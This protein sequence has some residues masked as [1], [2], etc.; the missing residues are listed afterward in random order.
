MKTYKKKI[1][2]NYTL[3][4]LIKPKLTFEKIN[5]YNILFI[6]NKSKIISVQSLI[7]NGFIHESKK[8]IGINHLLEHVLINSYKQCKKFNCY[9]YWNKIGA[10]G[11]AS[12]NNNIL[13]YYISGLLNNTDKMIN[14]IIDITVNPKFNNK[15]INKEKEAVHNELLIHIDNPNNSLDN[16][17]SKKFFTFDGLKYMKDSNLQIQNLKKFDYKYLIKYYQ[18]NYNNN[19]TIFIISGNYNKQHITKLLK[20][21]LPL[22]SIFKSI[23]NY[24][25]INCFT[26]EKKILHIKNP[27]LK[28]TKI[29]YYFPTP[30]HTS[31]DK[32]ITLII[33]CLIL[34]ILLLEK[35]RV[36]CNLIYNIK[37]KTITNTCGTVVKTFINTKNENLL[38][39]LKIYNNVINK[40]KKENISKTYI[41]AVKKKILIEFY[42]KK[43]NAIDYA[44]I[45]GIQYIYKHF[46]DTKI[47]SPE[48]LKNNIIKKNANDIRTII[49]ETFNFN[50]CM[51]A[52]SN[53]QSDIN[54]NQV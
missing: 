21:L 22:N 45:Y 17:I 25:K 52:Y 19:N 53:N 46:L 44:N 40:Y 31:S 18:Q 47:L 16:E 20:S 12:T 41:D 33:A 39:V 43:Y 28:S 6:K 51:M 42:S 23:I 35:L 34:Q 15:L 38:S 1:K 5:N 3:K 8:N 10:I 2:K 27:T 26:N 48:E 36:D 4:N 54:I 30:F 37:F 49:N 29:L 32:L 24:K 50:K 11:N 9:E 14:Y 13:N 7:F